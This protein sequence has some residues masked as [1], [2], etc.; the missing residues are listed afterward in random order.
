MSNNVSPKYQMTLVQQIS[1]R[2]FELFIGYEDVES[3]MMK[4]HTWDEDFYGRV[5]G[6]NFS[7]VY[8]DEEH[9]KIDA[10]K[11]LHGVDG[12]TLLKIAID[13]GIETPDFV[14]C[15]PTFRN[16]LK[17]SY[18]MAGQTF[19]K[20]FKNVDA[21]PSLAIGLANSALES[22]IK[23]ILEDKRIDV[24]WSEKDTLSGL[25]KTI[26]KAFQINTD[27]SCPVEIR[28]VAS[29]LM[30]CCK[31]IEDLRSDKT[32]FH[33]KTKEEYVVSDPLYAYFVVNAV[34]TI[35]L[36]MLN[37]YKTKYPS[38]SQFETDMEDDLPF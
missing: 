35:G 5:L 30:N 8:R 9:K 3:Y 36:F 19:E 23:K 31:A 16:E 38:N 22:I 6:E 1:D 21:D 13:L 32:V 26:C 10:K 27:N 4:W 34:S 29:S 2:L 24:Q 33:G 7:I 15:I 20:A 12:D 28:T 25:V 11:T 18:E 14:P 37:Y 17:S